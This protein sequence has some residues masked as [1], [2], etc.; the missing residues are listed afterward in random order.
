MK[1]K[2]NYDDIISL[3][4]ELIKK[5]TKLNCPIILG[6]DTNHNLV[7][8]DLKDVGNILIKGETG[9]G[10]SNFLHSI[11]CQLIIRLKPEEYQLFLVDP[12]QV[13]LVKYQGLPQVINQVF[14][15]PIGAISFLKTL[16]DKTDRRLA[17]LEENKLI[18][19]IIDTFSDLIYSN[20]RDFIDRISYISLNSLK[21]NIF[22]M[23]SDSK[24]SNEVFTDKINSIFKT[25]LTFGPNPGHIESLNLT[26]IDVMSPGEIEMIIQ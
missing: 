16:V 25:K 26:S 19:V 20:Q 23:M 1:Y 21:T 7:V 18:L 14:T 24:D 8:E 5:D 13:D 4:K 15:E 22:I 11:I 6:F 10:K 3:T 17:G 2:T 12:K 9:S